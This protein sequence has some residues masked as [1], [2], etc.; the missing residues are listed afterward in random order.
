MAA[1]AAEISAPFGASHSW[2]CWFKIKCADAVW[3]ELVMNVQMCVHSAR[4]T[5]PPSPNM[6]TT[7]YWQSESHVYYTCKTHCTLS[8]FT[9]TQRQNFALINKS[10][11]KD[12]PKGA[13]SS[14]AIAA[15][16][17]WNS[18]IFFHTRSGNPGRECR[19][20]RPVSALIKKSHEKD[21]PKG[22]GNSAAIAARL[23]HVENPNT[24]LCLSQHTFNTASWYHFFNLN[25]KAA[26]NM[27]GRKNGW[28]NM[29][30]ER[31][32]DEKKRNTKP[33]MS[34]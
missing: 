22:T 13:G 25:A 17:W 23:V 30:C 31:A 15:M 3:V 27:Q 14:V 8:S 1:I 5:P 10:I 2:N 33:L 18:E 29:I 6:T 20:L 12:A 19:K 16:F 32:W 21:A 34:K 9:R 7:E 24:C 11:E 4:V 26:N 28:L